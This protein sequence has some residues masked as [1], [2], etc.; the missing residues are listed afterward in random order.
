M[1]VFFVDEIAGRPG[2]YR[3]RDEAG[4]VIVAATGFPARAASSFL[5]APRGAD[6]TYVVTSRTLRRTD[7]SIPGV[8]GGAAARR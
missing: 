1:I 5:L 7:Y 3:L 4:R 8:I 6:V 2:I